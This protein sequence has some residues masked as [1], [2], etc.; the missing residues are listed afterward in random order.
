MVGAGLGA[1]G[2]GEGV[3]ALPMDVAGGRVHQAGLRA[4]GVQDPLGAARAQGV[5]FGPPG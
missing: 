4:V 5:E 1:H 2:L 3:G